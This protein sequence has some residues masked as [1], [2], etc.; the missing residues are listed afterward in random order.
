[1]LATSINV[2]KGLDNRTDVKKICDSFFIVV[3]FVPVFL[4][5]FAVVFVVVCVASSW[6]YFWLCLSS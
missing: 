3:V 1:M 5:V 4:V 6:V 2:Y